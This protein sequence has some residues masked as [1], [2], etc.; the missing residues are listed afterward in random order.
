MNQKCI[1]I[2]YKKLLKYLVE[3]KPTLEHYFLQSFSA[4]LTALNM[5]LTRLTF[6]P[7]LEMLLDCW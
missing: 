1:S 6:Q 2:V 5:K 7:V 4:H 3:Y